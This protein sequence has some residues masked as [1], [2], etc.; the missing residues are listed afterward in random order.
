MPEN[1]R[2]EWIASRQTATGSRVGRS[3]FIQ[4]R[5]LDLWCRKRCGVSKAGSAQMIGRSSR[6]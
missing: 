4:Q 1:R 2:A 6:G 5:P 3:L